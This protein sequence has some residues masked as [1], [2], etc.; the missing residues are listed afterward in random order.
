[1]GT[2]TGAS[3]VEVGNQRKVPRLPLLLPDSQELDSP[4]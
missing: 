2:V 4:D 3:G 1:M